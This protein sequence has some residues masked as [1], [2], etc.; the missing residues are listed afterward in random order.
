MRDE[1]RLGISNF[2]DIPSEIELTR[3]QLKTPKK[4]PFP[5]RE[6]LKAAGATSI[7]TLLASWGIGRVQASASS[8]RET[9][10]VG[11]KEN[12]V[13]KK[14]KENLQKIFNI[15][16]RLEKGGVQENKPNI[17]LVKRFVR[18]RPNENIY[19]LKWLEDASRDEKLKP[20]DYLDFGVEKGVKKETKIV[21][22][23][24]RVTGEDIKTAQKI[25]EQFD[26][27]GMTINIFD[28]SD[29]SVA[30]P[31]EPSDTGNLAY[32]VGD[33]VYVNIRNLDKLPHEAFHIFNDKAHRYLSPEQYA[34]FEKFKAQLLTG[35]NGRMYPDKLAKLLEWSFLPGRWGADKSFA[36]AVNFY[37]TQFYFHGGDLSKLREEILEDSA[38]KINWGE[39]DFENIKNFPDFVKKIILNSQKLLEL[40]K[41]GLFGEVLKDMLVSLS[42][43]GIEEGFAYGLGS[44]DPRNFKQIIKRLGDRTV[45]SWLWQGGKKEE[46]LRKYMSAE[47][48]KIAKERLTALVRAADEE[49]LADAIKTVHL[50][51]GVIPFQADLLY[52]HILES[53]N[54][55]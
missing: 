26:F 11:T 36:K 32:H 30:L 44:D 25:I 34:G 17:D 55:K 43:V 18:E 3:R 19:A 15:Q 24:K 29:K 22:L 14:A 9:G 38:L 49:L 2:L 35:E 40:N 5:R 33:T 7:L 53:V 50:R 8:S 4:N 20:V 23:S 51:N 37:A 28:K 42:T 46:I 27:L 41:N 10:M 52:R 39:I 16:D 31:F 12:L 1:I 6:F 54:G 13:E 47:D 45:A 21:A 48:I